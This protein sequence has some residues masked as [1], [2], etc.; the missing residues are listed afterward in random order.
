ML[1]ES[2]K[3]VLT[4]RP[5]P[6]FAERLEQ[7]LLAKQKPVEA[8][9]AGAGRSALSGSL[10][11]RWRQWWARIASPIRRYRWT[12]VSLTILLLLLSGL[13]II[14]P[15]RAWAE[16]QAW[17]GY[18]PG[19]GFVDL[20]DTR[21]LLTPAVETR[22]GITLRVTEVVAG[23]E[24]TT[25]VIE[26]EGLPPEEALWGEESPRV[27]E[28]FVPRLLQ[29]NGTALEVET[30]TVRYGRG[31]LV[32]P[33]L[34]QNVYHLTL[35]L[36]LLPLVPPG[37]A[38]ENWS[39]PL[40]LQPATG[41]VVAE[42]YPSP[43]RP[44]GAT[45]THHGITLR[46]EEVAHTP[47]KTV[48][49]VQTEWQEEKW[50]DVSP[51]F[52]YQGL[53]DDL[54]HVYGDYVETGSGSVTTMVERIQPGETPP[55]LSSRRTFDFAPVSLAANTL[56]FEAPQVEA[57]VPATGTFT[58]DLG[59]RPQVGDSWDLDVHLNVAGFPVHITRAWIG[60][61]QHQLGPDKF[62]PERIN[63]YFYLA[64]VPPQE[65]KYL[66]SFFLA[67][68]HSA[69]RGSGSQG[70]QILTLNLAENA[71]L[72]TGQIEVQVEHARVA[73][74]GPWVLAW[75]LPQTA[76][77]A[78]TLLDPDLSRTVDDVTLRLDSVAMSDRVTGVEVTLADA[79]PD[80]ALHQIL[81]GV[82]GGPQRTLRLEDDR[83]HDYRFEGGTQTWWQPDDPIPPTAVSPP[84]WSKR[85]HFP[86]VQPLA[87]QLTLRIPAI[88]LARLD[89]AA[90]TVEAPEDI[91]FTEDENGRRASQLWPVNLRFTIAGYT[92]HF[93]E[94][95]LTK[96]TPAEFQAGMTLHGVA[97]GGERSGCNLYGLRV[98]AITGPGGHPI[99]SKQ[100]SG[101]IFAGP[102][103]GIHSF[104]GPHPS[105]KDACEIILS[106]PAHDPDTGKTQAGRYQVE[107]E[108][109]NEIREGPWMFSWS[110][111]AN[112]GASLFHL[113]DSR[114]P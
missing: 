90:F 108:G 36:P 16:L 21:V 112:E 81:P 10:S 3:V 63:L 30:F 61:E 97:T 9:A 39:L 85:L 31:A 45:D 37:V 104:A 35:Q 64:P 100:A 103:P 1:E 23:P 19:V 86:P 28:A 22:D 107:L 98:G 78:P 69:F 77:M 48:F 47:Q 88:S 110:L 113:S 5:D 109:V 12:A 74:H 13:L 76:E 73:F 99:Q 46:V 20:E 33:P 80:V 51:G 49:V 17:L 25:L 56:T 94:A 114:A 95:R 54:G 26:S 83:L 102:L 7:R 72:P 82:P 8:D 93:T 57:R 91:A 11:R 87:Q 29:A 43:Y 40:V 38:P 89:T 84:V 71:P 66:S 52:V 44:Q 6:E 111:R 55:P 18:V 101:L 75:Q 65:D 67:S 70:Q 41:E 15:E 34:P 58:L 62:G 59:E 96:D 4:H 105:D 24:E 32:F 79:P 92:I 106:F 27:D 50:E 60:T 42:I 53:S 14:G 68:D 2:L